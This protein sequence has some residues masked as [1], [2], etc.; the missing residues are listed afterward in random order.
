MSAI[1]V[2]LIVATHMWNQQEKYCTW[3]FIAAFFKLRS[4]CNWPFNA[5]FLLFLSPS[6]SAFQI[7]TVSKGTGLGLN[8]V[9]G[10]NRNEGPLV[11]I[12]EVIPGGDCHKVDI[13]KSSFIHSS[14]PCSSIFF[15]ICY[16]PQYKCSPISRLIYFDLLC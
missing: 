9:G 11:Y 2:E 13:I 12:Q 16:Q 10:I 14:F 8:I 6:D 7:I 3:V 4:L 1:Y 5:N 15:F